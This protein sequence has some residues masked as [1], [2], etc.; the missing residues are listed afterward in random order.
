MT[1]PAHWRK[2]SQRSPTIDLAPHIEHSDRNTGLPSLAPSP[3]PIN[4]TSLR[5]PRFGL[6]NGLAIYALNEILIFSVSYLIAKHIFKREH[7]EAFLLAMAM[8]FVNS[9]L[10]IWPISFL[11]YGEAAALPIT[12][13]VAWDASVAFGFFIIS[14]EMMTGKSSNPAR[15]IIR[16]P[17]LIAIILGTIASLTQFETP[18]PALTFMEFTGAAAA[19]LTLF[20]LGRS[21]PIGPNCSL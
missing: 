10:Y 15:A 7:L 6:W 19:P 16:N 1:Q 8:I 3:H 11:I 13:I 14:L 4:S 21:R 20:A 9:L 18:T 12:A 5:D 2:N 17:V